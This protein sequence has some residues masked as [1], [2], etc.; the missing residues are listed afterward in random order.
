M[1]KVFMALVT[2]LA[3]SI[4]VVGCGEMVDTTVSDSSEQEQRHDSSGSQETIQGSPE[5]ES[6]TTIS[7]SMGISLEDFISDLTE[8][9]YK[10]AESSSTETE[11]PSSLEETILGPTGTGYKAVESPDM[12]AEFPSSLEDLILGPT[13]TGYRS[14]DTP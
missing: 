6:K 13:G 9:G 3:V 11:F 1:K 2:I 7:P 4:L 5:T 10:G 12:E 14:A 8:T